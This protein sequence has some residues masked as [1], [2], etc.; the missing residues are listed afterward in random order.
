MF[1]VKDSEF[2][3]GKAPM[4][5][6]EIRFVSLGKLQVEEND[7]CLDIGGG[8]GSITVE[9]ALFAKKG[10][11]YSIEMK[12]DAFDTM[13]ENIEKFNLSN[14]TL[15]KGNAPA[16]LPSFP[17]RLNKIFIGGSG[18]N[19]DHIISY[20]YDNLDNNGILCMN[21]IVLENTFQAIESLKKSNFKNIDIC[22]LIVSKNRK[23]KDFNMMMAENPI[24]IITAE[25]RED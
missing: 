17:M 15:I 4:T 19:L 14:V 5:K 11:V 1:H 10:H 13:N 8:T 21:F 6:E 18:G 22:Q 16:D 23:V 24:Y 20:S 12:D 25:K 3:R 7:I 9:M 2:I